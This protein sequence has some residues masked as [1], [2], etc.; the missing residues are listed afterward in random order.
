[1]L[2]DKDTLM[3]IINGAHDARVAKLDAKEDELRTMETKACNG[4]VQRCGEAR[5]PHPHPT[6]YPTPY[7]QP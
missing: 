1:M 3:G 7:P 4:L 5:T 6:P 2:S